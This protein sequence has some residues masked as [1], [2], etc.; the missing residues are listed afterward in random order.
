MAKF[1]LIVMDCDGVILESVDAKTQAFGKLVEK[2]GQKAKQKMV[3]YHLTHGGV[4]RFLKFEWFYHEVLGREITKQE[5]DELGRLFTQY[6]F[7]EVMNSSFVPGAMEFIVLYYE[8]ISLYVASGAPHEE[9]IEI[10]KGRNL[11]HF[12]KGVYGSPPTK[13]EILADIVREEGVLPS[14][15]LMVGDS[16]TDLEAATSV[17]TFFYGR[18]IEFSSSK[19]P[20]AEDLT[21]LSEYIKNK[22]DE[23]I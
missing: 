3:D 13:T 22:K 8:K 12:F 2:Y 4:S 17:G 7:S 1:K 16:S 23:D 20:W 15:T 5:Q 9:L 18:G 19:W 11:M 14:E 10:I 6:C 21:Q